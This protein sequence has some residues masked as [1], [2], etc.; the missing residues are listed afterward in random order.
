MTPP[1]GNV[2][3]NPGF[4]VFPQIKPCRCWSQTESYKNKGNLTETEG[5][6]QRERI[7]KKQQINSSQEF[8][9]IE[10]SAIEYNNY[11]KSL[12]IRK[13]EFKTWGNRKS[14]CTIHFFFYRKLWDQKD[15]EMIF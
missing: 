8:E 14:V 12:N 11:F 15:I 3:P 1:R 5:E 13:K 6:T 4:T 9:I 10:L 7:P 2:N